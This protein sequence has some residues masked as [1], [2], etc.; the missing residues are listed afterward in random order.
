M[1]AMADASRTRL[2]LAAPD[3]Y[4]G[5]VGAKELAHAVAAA[6]TDA[7]W[8]CDECPVSDGGEG[9]ADVVS[10][11]ATSPRS[12]RH[13]TADGPDSGRWIDTTVTGPLG[14]PVVARWYLGRGQA[15]IESATA[16][17]LPLAGGAAGNDPVAATTRGTGELIA[18][19]VAAGARRILIGVGGSATTDGGLGAMEAIDG[20]GGLKGVDVVVACD[21]QTPFVE[22]ADVFGPQKGASPDQIVILRHRLEA[23]VDRYRVE[24]AVDVSVLPSAGAA[25]G[26]AGGLA[27]LGARLVPGFAVVAEAVS[28]ADRLGR[29]DLVVTGEGR[30]DASSW[31]GKVVG[32]VQEMARIA[33][34]PVLVVAGTLGVGGARPGL[35]FVDLTARFGVETA[36]AEPAACVRAVVRQALGQCLDDRA[37]SGSP[38]VSD[39]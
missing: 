12:G 18:A 10:L 30:L 21:V 33:A 20:S 15:V 14:R 26:L 23:L 9:F 32:E 6:A 22:A 13:D 11:A 36:L 25:G 16:S 19:A 28:L 4:K 27:A 8:L 7:G 39:P 2:V 3:A 35:E 17:G 31:S 5:T 29:A 34:V 1:S 38:N 24:R 37:G